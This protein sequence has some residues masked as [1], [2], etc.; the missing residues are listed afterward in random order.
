[1]PQE[2]TAS[3]DKLRAHVKTLAV[4]TDGQHKLP[5]SVINHLATMSCICHRASLPIRSARTLC[6]QS[7]WQTL[8]GTDVWLTCLVNYESDR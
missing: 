2:L 7:C 8:P 1:M 4:P 5:R 3:V 6:Y